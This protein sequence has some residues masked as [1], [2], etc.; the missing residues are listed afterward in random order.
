MWL[1]IPSLEPAIILKEFT[2]KVNK[3]QI[4]VILKEDLVLNLEIYYCPG[5]DLALGNLKHKDLFSYMERDGGGA[6]FRFQ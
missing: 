6:F 4:N 5:R 2:V 3:Y 1:V